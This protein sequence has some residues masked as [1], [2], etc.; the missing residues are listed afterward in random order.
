[1]Q[2]EKWKNLVGNI[3][4][5]FEV[6]DE[7][8][9]SSDEHGGAETEFIV[10][11]GPLGRIRLEYATRPVVLDKKTYYSNRLGGE[12]TVEYVYSET[13]KAHKLAVKKWDDA[14]DEWVEIDAKKF[15]F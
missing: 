6:V 14:A 10:F 9:E 2:P 7:G 15:T 4:D 3:K 11:D 1:M 8:A 12:T 5:K 13:E